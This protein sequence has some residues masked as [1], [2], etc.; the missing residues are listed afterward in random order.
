[1]ADEHRFRDVERIEQADHVGAQDLHRVLGRVARR[2]GATVAAHVRRNRTQTVVAERVQL[3]APGIPELRPAV[4]HHHRK[5]GARRRASKC[6]SL[7][8]SDAE[9]PPLPG[10]WSQD[11]IIAR[12]RG[13]HAQEATLLEPS[14]VFTPDLGNLVQLF[15]MT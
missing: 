14:Q 7:K 12:R 1:V 5:P 8:L 4:A 6:R 9:C 3:M 13:L 11:A 10:P 2:I 15:V